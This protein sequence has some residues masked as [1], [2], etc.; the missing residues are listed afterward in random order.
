MSLKILLS[1]FAGIGLGYFFLPSNFLQYTDIVIDIGLCL[2]LF[3]VGID[4]GRQKD[5]FSNIK[6][7]GFKI[8]LVPFGIIVGGILGGI[9]G[10]IVL[11]MPL[12]EAGAIGS[13]LGWYT[14]SSMMVVGYSTELSALAFL[15]NVIR[16]VIA[17]ILVPFV[18]K[19][20]GYIESISICGATAMDTAL[21]VI[22]KFTDSQ[23]TIIAFISGLISTISVPIILPIILRF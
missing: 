22:S 19:H 3:F 16:E 13:G 21:P 4:I 11:S 14:L 12:S 5:I 6:T 7:M 9:F 17:L 20:I 1:I 18:A 10:G 23:T 15:S 2:L 8:L